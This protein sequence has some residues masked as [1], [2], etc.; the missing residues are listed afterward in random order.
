MTLPRYQ[1]YA[2]LLIDGQP[3]RPF[4]MRTLPPPRYQLDPKREAIIRRY[5]TAAVRAKIRDGGR[6]DS[7]GDG[8]LKVT[9]F[10]C[11]R[12]TLVSDAKTKRSN[13]RTMQVIRPL[14]FLCPMIPS[15]TRS[16]IS[17]RITSTLGTA[18][19]SLSIFAVP[20]FVHAAALTNGMNASDALGQYDDSLTNPQPVYTKSAA[21][22]GPN[23]LGFGAGGPVCT[24][25]DASASPVISSEMSPIIEFL[26]II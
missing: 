25:L 9:R 4:S 10:D 20:I 12:I 22:N 26:S 23:S 7:E 2:R 14:L 16:S 15:R 5:F 6:G 17:V 3:S 1:A 8:W 13:V 19:L 18:F 11:L 24:A 21:N